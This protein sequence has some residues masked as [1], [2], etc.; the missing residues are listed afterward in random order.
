MQSD[1][2]QRYPNA[3]FGTSSSISALVYCWM[4]TKHL[5]LSLR[6]TCIRNPLLLLCLLWYRAVSNWEGLVSWRTT[7]CC[8]IRKQH[9]TRKFYFSDFCPSWNIFW[10][11]VTYSNQLTKST[12]S[13]SFGIEKAIIKQKGETCK[14]NWMIQVKTVSFWHNYLS[15]S[16][17][18]QNKAY[19]KGS[20]CSK[21]DL[22]V[23]LHFL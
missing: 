3:T 9:S 10:Y 2:V 8:M 23:K 5:W 20:V 11:I 22:N 6:N 4:L 16:S 1:P 18:F 7:V 17:T 12:Q 19:S 13:F 14:W 21:A 15:N